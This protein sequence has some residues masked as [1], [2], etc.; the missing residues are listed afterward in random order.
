[1]N[2]SH[3]TKIKFLYFSKYLYQS[4]MELISTSFIKS[5]RVDIRIDL[6][7]KNEAVSC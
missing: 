2:S 3:K 6:N 5:V 1:M 4:A 7:I